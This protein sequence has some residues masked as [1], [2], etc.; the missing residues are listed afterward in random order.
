MNILKSKKFIYFLGIGGIGMSALARYFLHLGK[1]IAGY[2]RTETSLTKQLAGEGINIHYSDDINLIPQEFANPDDTLVVFTPAI[3]PDNHELNYFKEKEFL[4]IKRAEILGLISR[5]EPT[6]AIAGSHGKT[7]VS[8]MI[9]HIFY[10][11]QKGCNAFLGGIAK[12]FNSNLVLKQSGI[13][14]YFITEAD[15]FDRSFLQL[16]PSAA[17]IT[18]SDPD[19]LDIYGS[20]QSMISAFESF[21]DR[22]TSQ[23]T[24]VI[25]SGLPIKLNR[26]DIKIFTYSVDSNSDFYPEIIDINNGLY[27][28]DLIT[29]FGKYFNLKM[30]IPGI[31]NV[32]NAIAACAIAL[33][34]GIGIDEIKQALTGFSGIVRRFDYQINTGKIVYIDDYAHH[35]NEIKAVL[36]SLKQIYPH[37]RITGIFQPHLYSRTRDFATEFAS[38]LEIL[39]EIIL[40]P[41]YPARELPIEGVSSDL[42]FEKLI[43]PK[44][45]FIE[46]SDLL[47]LLAS[48]DVDILITMGAGDIDGMVKPITEL[49]INK[50]L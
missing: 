17:V 6:I 29:P 47:K 46:K 37:R 33:L 11:S 1:V 25:K 5:G 12:N 23:G 20:A 24:L 15:E 35:P 49:L 43:N 16:S 41:I 48:L 2:D 21:I 14:D 31:L 45:T 22:I 38:S 8:S 18:S 34:H 27:T 32:E 28:F 40:L 30:G 26:N 42:I 44:K 13:D 4:L 36:N 10:K 19:H 9:A 50:A 39:D 7:T 3:P